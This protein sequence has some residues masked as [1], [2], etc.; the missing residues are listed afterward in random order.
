[1]KVIDC[2]GRPREEADDV[3]AP[4]WIATGRGGTGRIGSED[5]LLALISISESI[6]VLRL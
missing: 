5:I 1:V 3:G 4:R 6:I 2:G